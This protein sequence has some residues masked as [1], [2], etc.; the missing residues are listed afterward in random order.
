MT[1]KIVSSLLILTL[2]WPNCTW[3][4]NPQL[5]PEEDFESRN[6][7]V[8]AA[9]NLNITAGGTVSFAPK[10]LRSEQTTRRKT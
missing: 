9:K 3:A 4:R 5:A 8:P 7:A 6:D 1:K 2:V 10:I